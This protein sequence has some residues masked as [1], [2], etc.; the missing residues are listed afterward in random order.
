MN[1]FDPTKGNNIL[2][3]VGRPGHRFCK[4]LP[5]SKPVTL[6]VGI[7]CK[8]A[9]VLAADSQT[10]KGMAKIPG[11]QKISVVEFDGARALVAESGSASLSNRAIQLFQSKAAG[12]RVENEFTIAEIAEAT[13]GATVNSQSSLHPN[14]TSPTAWQDFWREEINYFE[15]MV[16]YYF[17]EKP[18]L[19]KFN[20]LWCIP[21]PAS[22]YFM[23]S[24]CA[25]DLANYLLKEN[26]EPGMDS[27]FAS[28][29]AIKV[30]EDAIEYVEGCGAPT[31]VAMIRKPVE[32]SQISTP[33]SLTTST[34]GS[35]VILFPQ[36]KVEEIAK[37]I[38][39]VES[40]TK[41]ARM[42]QIHEELKTE[43]NSA[44]EEI[45]KDFYVKVRANF[46]TGTGEGK[47]N[48]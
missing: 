35:N 13:I 25:A 37:T 46:G 24:G 26:T 5:K 42:V 31:R 16:A 4:F 12:V 33:F 39:A 29:I 17:R 15:L 34:Y 23:T 30:V 19:Y 48:E 38:A 27:E 1:Q 7:V 8:D 44:L 20:P 10:T 28:V 45:M 21:V 32:Y 43:T 41:R 3:S 2:A 47:Q 6:I 36:D 11:A 22:S 18:C 40:K 14:A 9:I